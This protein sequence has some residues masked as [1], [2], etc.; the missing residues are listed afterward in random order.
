MKKKRIRGSSCLFDDLP[1]IL[2]TMKLICLF[3][4]VALL[5]VSASSYSQS[6]KL[7]VSGQNLAL[8]KVFE[9]IEDQSEF[10][11]IYNLKQ[12]DLSQK[13]NVNFKNE[14]VE[15]I[16]DQ[17][18]DGT[19][20]TYTV[21]NRLIVVH[22]E[23][24]KD[25]LGT[26][27]VQ[28]K[29][30]S[31]KVTD[32]AGEPLPGVTVL[33]KGTTR[34]TVT[35]FDGEFNLAEVTS[36][37]VLQ[38]S[39]VGM[40]SQEVVV[41]SQHNINVSMVVDAIGIEEVVA[42]GYGTQKREQITTAVSQI[43]SEEF[44]K[45]S[46]QDAASLIQGKVAGLNVTRSS[47]DPNSLSQFNLRGI[48]TINSNIQPLVLIDGIPGDMNTVAP[49]DIESIDILKD[50]SAAAIYG[51]RGTNGVIL[52]T[53]KSSNINTPTVVNFNAYV[54]AQS[55]LNTP[56]MMSS[57]EYRKLAQQGVEGTIDYGY[58]TDWLDLVTQSPV[59]QVYN[60]SF[61]GGN[62]KTSYTVN[63]N[64]KNLEGVIKDSQNEKL[65]GRASF[66]HR[67][68]DNK[69]RFDFTLS[70][71]N[72]KYNGYNGGIY[73]NALTYNPTDRPKD[74][75]GVWNEHPSVTDYQNPV[76]LLEETIDDREVIN[77]RTY[78]KI[79]V[80]PVESVTLKAIGSMDRKNTD[81]GYYQTTKHY[82]AARNNVKGTARRYEDNQTEKLF[83]ATAL[84]QKEFDKHAVT[85]LAG[86]GYREN[87][88]SGFY[89]S[90]YNFT[91]DDAT[92]NNLNSG[93]ALKQGKASM[94]S[95]KTASTLV[96]YFGRLN[97]SFDNRYMVM[98]SVRHEGSTKF[99]DNNKWGTFP[100]VSAGW[101]VHREDF[102]SSFDELSNL[103]LRVGYGL[104][105]TEPNESY[106][107]LS[108]LRFDRY[109]YDN[110]Q[111]NP[112]VMPANNPNPDLK[113]EVKTEVN[114]G[115]D[116][117]FW[118]NRLNGAIDVYSRRTEDLIMS[119]PVP[120]PPYLYG[121]I[122]ANAAV[123]DNKGV[124]VN[125]NYDVLKKDDLK[126]TTTINYSKNVNELVRL[127]SDKFQIASGYIDLGNTYEPLT[128]TYQ[129]IE[130]GEPIGNFFGY[131]TVGITD[132]GHWLIEGADGNP[133]PIQEQLPSDRQVIGNG[134]PNF[135]LG[136]NNN[137]SYKNWDLSVLMRGA[138]GFDI[139]NTNRLW[140]DNPVML[141]R[142]NVLSTAFDDVYGKRP[143]A[144]SQELN[145]VSYYLEKGDYWKIDNVTLGYNITAKKWGVDKIYLY[146]TGTNLITITGYS[147]MDPEV[148]TSYHGNGLI[149]GIDDRNRYPS[150]RTFTLGVNLTF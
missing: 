125:L 1:K 126:W 15:K 71:Y 86:Y 47:G 117:G 74:D 14:R 92:Y 4:F 88:Y 121:S 115:V 103:K 68:F 52:I 57:T 118:E 119:Y 7:N 93:A 9:I 23:G 114:F 51:T 142:G 45:G 73:R 84:F 26:P 27:A 60:L 122:L 134:T 130:I 133:K 21:N 145:Y 107:S 37:S 150:T 13:V 106:M 85:A 69:L 131:K 50:G 16:L 43:K 120:S 105:G 62:K 127:N 20:I 64:Y 6:A 111:W 87:I 104:T 61:S 28:Q 113:W 147:G 34:G 128:T 89:A 112:S 108:L 49:E 90:N 36:E 109:Y 94:S 25:L 129:R 110:G 39:F 18:L 19:N 148:S 101:N 144:T 75:N 22:R 143:L 70:G 140:Y 123:M 33:I 44:N 98:A 11:F 97:Y 149:P 56:E 82:N 79:T 41:G 95:Y 35:N 58:D 66:S 77:Y 116:F 132:E 3:M 83:E 10:S 91:S 8:E 136:W 54:T 80:M 124:E 135:N 38:F 32:E 63:L 29:S 31:G 67:E 138:F 46:V 100:A 30:V 99:G 12:V 78:G 146:A 24:E 48:A 42:V 102:M 72:Q 139:A 96:S 141:T 53:T 137:F 55:L 17:V 81:R 59:S 5:Q 76:A 40:L 2:R 65:T